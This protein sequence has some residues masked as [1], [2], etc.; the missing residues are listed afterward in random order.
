MGNEN[1]MLLFAVPNTNWV[2]ATFLWA[3]LEEVNLSV[4][5]EAV[6]P[7]KPGTR[8]VCVLIM[9]RVASLLLPGESYLS[10]ILK[11]LGATR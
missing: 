7:A 11:R 10:L 9:Q 3:D 4:D 5:R 1:A 2:N 6:N 8:A